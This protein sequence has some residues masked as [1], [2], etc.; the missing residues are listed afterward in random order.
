MFM[1]EERVNTVVVNFVTDVSSN[2]SESAKKTKIL[3]ER[4]NDARNI[5]LCRVCGAWWDAR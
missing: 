4:K 3:L 5:M 2:M 1:A